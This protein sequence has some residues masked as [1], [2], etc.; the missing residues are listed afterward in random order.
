MDCPP[1]RIVSLTGIKTPDGTAAYYNVIFNL[2]D[3]VKARAFPMPLPVFATSREER[4]FLHKQPMIKTTLDL[5]A[6]ANVTFLGIG[7][8]ND[9]A[10]L[11]EDGFISAAELNALQKSGGVGEIVGWTCDREGRIIDG[12]SNDR[13]ASAPTPD[14]GASLVIAIAK[15]EKKLPGIEGAIKRR[16]INGLITDE[17]TAEALLGGG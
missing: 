4:D 2:A 8:L 17:L 1:H 14:R 12:M 5:A 10:P 3:K 11:H 9:E 6:K 16:I 15:G 13:V 7:E